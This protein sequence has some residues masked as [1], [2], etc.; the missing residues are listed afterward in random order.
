MKDG[1]YMKRV[2][3]LII[4]L[5]ITITTLHV[6]IFAEQPLSDSTLN[7]PSILTECAEN[8]TSHALAACISANLEQNKKALIIGGTSGI[9]LATAVQL[10]ERGYRVIIVGRHKPDETLLK[11]SKEDQFIQFN[12]ND[13]DFSFLDRIDDIDVLIFAA[14][15]GRIASFSDISDAEIKND[16][17]VNT[18][19]A[20]RIIKK[21]YDKINSSNNF[22]TAVITSVAGEMSSP[23]FAL[24]SATKS[25]LCKFIE[26][27]NIELEMEGSVNK[28]LNITPGYIDG[29]NF[30]G[31]GVT[32]I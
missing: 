10:K 24:Y 14:G 1:V 8:G 19:A 22:Y 17:R 2:F 20:I 15:V 28:I 11:L 26:S 7:N 6:S 9:G 29:T 4:S 18:T 5:L 23:L 27:V 32:D 31:S 16:F 21:Y 30:Y 13:E 25:A 3:S 12:L